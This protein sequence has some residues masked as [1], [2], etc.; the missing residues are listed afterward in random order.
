KDSG[1]S[2][3]EVDVDLNNTVILS[4]DLPIHTKS[5]PKLQSTS[6]DI[7]LP[8]EKETTEN[9]C[10]QLKTNIIQNDKSEV[11]S[12]KNSNKKHEIMCTKDNENTVKS[13]CQN[14]EII[15]KINKNGIL[16]E[17]TDTENSENPCSA[18]FMKL[19]HKSEKSEV[20]S[21][22]DDDMKDNLY[23]II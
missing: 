16:K 20:N 19:I 10:T 4:A 21:K 6:I 8:Y 22:M 13:N 14:S 12:E 11:H 15:D 7:L 3:I 23:T 1:V 2:R 18:S 17:C 9:L 5:C